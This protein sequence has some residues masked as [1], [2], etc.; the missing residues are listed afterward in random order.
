MDGKRKYEWEISLYRLLE[1]DFQ[2]MYLFL[3]IGTYG[4]ICFFITL[5]LEITKIISDNNVFFIICGDVLENNII[6]NVSMA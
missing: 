2:Y 1:A 6:L 4:R 3:E 5:G